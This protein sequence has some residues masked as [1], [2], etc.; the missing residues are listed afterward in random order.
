MKIIILSGNPKTEGLCQSMIE[1]VQQG[2]SEAGALVE[3]IRI[4]DLPLVRCQ[5]CGNG[6]GTCGSENRCSFG[7]DGFDTLQAELRTGDAFVLATPVYWG[8]MAE[9]LK[10]FLDRLRRCERGREGSLAGK[11]VILLATP[12][13][14]GNGQLSCLEQMDRFSRHVGLVIFDYLGANRW[15]QDYKRETAR[16][17]GQMLASGRQN[18]MTA[19]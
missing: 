6:W 17:A 2:A 8:E 3:V 16:K 4:S 18:G 10:C 15:T 5:V 12:G 14:S 9:G 7:D 19:L 1:A 13:G 11:Q